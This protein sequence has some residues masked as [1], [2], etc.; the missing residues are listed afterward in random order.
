MSQPTVRT[1]KKTDNDAI[2]AVVAPALIA[3]ANTYRKRAIKLICPACA[4][5]YCPNFLQYARLDTPIAASFLDSKQ[6]CQ[7]C[8]A[9]NR[10]SAG[11]TDPANYGGIGAAFAQ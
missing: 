4:A 7:I 11:T 2:P 8:G 9:A 1:V 6:P 5:Q 3:A 10:Y